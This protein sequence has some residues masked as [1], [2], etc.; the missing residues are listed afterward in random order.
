MLRGKLHT[1]SCVVSR[2]SWRVIKVDTLHS[3]KEMWVARLRIWIQAENLYAL[4]AH[5]T[6]QYFGTTMGSALSFLCL[7]ERPV[8]MFVCARGSEIFSSLSLSLSL[9]LHENPA[10]ERYLVGSKKIDRYIQCLLTTR[11]ETLFSCCSAC[12]KHLPERHK[13]AGGE[14]QLLWSLNRRLRVTTYLLSMLIT[15]SLVTVR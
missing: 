15:N 12:Q 4:P 14:I 1:T 9:S 7:V 6:I 11:C 10:V 2:Y 13:T 3:V 8:K 5:A